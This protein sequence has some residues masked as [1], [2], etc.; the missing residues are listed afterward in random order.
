MSAFE[1]QF[2]CLS[3]PV[4]PTLLFNGKSFLARISF[5]SS[6]V[7]DCHRLFVIGAAYTLSVNEIGRLGR[8]LQ[9]QF[10]IILVLAP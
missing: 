1:H 7:T 6:A 10:A 5:C 8:W 9:N 4:Y 3:H 2:Q